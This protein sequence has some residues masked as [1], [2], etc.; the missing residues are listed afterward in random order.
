MN[1][2]EQEALSSLLDVQISFWYDGN[3]HMSELVRHYI[4]WLRDEYYPDDTD[5][6]LMW[7]FQGCDSE[8]DRQAFVE[9]AGN[10]DICN[11]I[12]KGVQHVD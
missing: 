9:V 1:E 8:S 10:C 12:T 7:V 4:E 6:P 2:Q 3:D 5:K 11:R